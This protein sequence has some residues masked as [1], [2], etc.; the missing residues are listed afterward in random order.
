MTAIPTP[1]PSPLTARASVQGALANSST[2]IITVDREGRVLQSNTAAWELLGLDAS[3]TVLDELWS[4]LPID[5][6]SPK[7]PGEPSMWTGDLTRRGRDGVVR[8][9]QIEVAVSRDDHGVVNEATALL[10]DTSDAQRLHRELLHQ[11]SHDALTGLANRAHFRRET[12]EAVE[13]LRRQGG[14][15]AVLFVDLDHLKEVNDVAGHDVGD[16]VIVHAGQRLV[17][18][19]RPMDLVARLGGD[20]FVVLCEGVTDAHAALE[21]AER[22]RRTLSDRAEFGGRL[23]T[24]ASSIGVAVVH[25]EQVRSD[26]RSPVD[27]ADALLQ[28][29][30]SAMYRAKQRG[31]ARSEVF[32]D[33]LGRQLATR[34]RRGDDLGEALTAG[35]LDVVWTP[36]IDLMTSTVTAWFVRASWHTPDGTDLGHDEIVDLAAR[37]GHDRALGRWMLRHAA[38]GPAT[39]SRPTIMIPWTAAQLCDP[40]AVDVARVSLDS[41]EAVRSL[42]VT[43]D[44]SL[45][46]RT[47]D[48]VER[49]LRALPRYGIRLGVTGVGRSATPLRRFA[50]LPVTRLVL[51]PSVVADLGGSCPAEAVARALIHMGH[52]LD[53]VVGAELGGGDDITLA[54]RTERLRALGCDDVLG[55]PTAVQELTAN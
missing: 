32:D 52:T 23:F 17:A 40:D 53:M 20:E 15:I 6:R 28:Q 29:A 42:M 47:D 12:A 49:T 22:I 14:T 1:D 18:S 51:D 33:E 26:D 30:D 37:A 43:V 16:Q 39:T 36:V 25:A 8:T 31:R 24:L 46:V 27:L 13:R 35:T 2:G 44:E 19:V 45:L 10:R 7:D 41:A 5:I 4:V 9:L 34:R 48:D 21:V 50:E 3:A 38:A 55:H 54:R 11:A